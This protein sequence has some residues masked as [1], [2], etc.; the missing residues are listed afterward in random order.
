MMPAMRLI[1]ALLVIALAAA[2]APPATAAEKAKEHIVGTARALDGD[3]IMVT[4]AAGKKHRVRLWG[5][6]APEMD[7]P[8]GSG[9]ASRA[10]LDALLEEG[11][12]SVDCEHIDTDKYKRPVGHCRTTQGVRLGLSVET[13]RS[14]WA[15][16]HRLYSDR[17]GMED[18]A[19][20]IALGEIEARKARRGRWKFIYGK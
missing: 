19:A 4:D 8:D 3:T 13:V 12:N 1:I 14:G 17:P 10:A 20:W 7:S 16:E 18:I 15:V 11:E 6:D 5:I 2:P 9:W